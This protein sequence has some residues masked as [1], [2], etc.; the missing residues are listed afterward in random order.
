[1]TLER[2]AELYVRAEA[3]IPAGVSSPVRA[4]RKVGGTPVYFREAQGAYAVDE[5]GNRYLDLCMAWGPLILGH[6]HPR[7]VEAV[8]RAAAQGLALGTAHRLEGEL[9]ERVLAAY[10]YA[11][12]V[13]FVVS[14]TEAVA[15]AVRIARASNG[16]RR[17]LKFDGC[18]HGHV[19]ALMV[20]AGSG[21]I[22]QGLADSA[23]VPA[24]VAADTLVIPLGDTAALERAFAE[25][26][27][28][29]AAAIIEPL[30][31][32][33]GLLQQSR[34]WLQKLRDLTRAHGAVLIFDEVIT[35]F[36]FGFHG[37]DKLLGIEPDLTTLGKIVGGGLPVAAVLGRRELLAQLAPLGP[38]YQAGTMAGNPV[39]LA[40]GVA[41][42]SE[43]AEGGVYRHLDMLGK[44]LDAAFARHALKSQAQLPRVGPIV[45]P[46]FETRAALPVAASSISASAIEEYHRRY[47]GW[48]AH[49][50]YLP[51]SAY[52]VCFLSAAHSTA[53]VDKLLDVL[54]TSEKV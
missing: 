20:K 24:T 3:L 23:G 9:A 50:V 36:R 42:L 26:G 53:D 44:H 2:S 25:A 17:I 43:L 46:Y 54:A 34:E 12:L 6:A 45:W 29:I 19:D 32:N 28:D 31:A 18:Y 13:R 35:G 52:E 27:K 16:R 8:Q 37:Y 47:R 11:K 38:V 7:V 14:G 41:T 51:P 4:F 5:D 39:C 15:T 40:A 10:P 1:M 49:G 22:T 33:N 30:P 21:V 48:L